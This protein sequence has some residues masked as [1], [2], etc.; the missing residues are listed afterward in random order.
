MLPGHQYTLTG[1]SNTL[2]PVTG[3][4]LVTPTIME[5]AIDAVLGVGAVSVFSVNVGATVT[6]VV[7][8]YNSVNGQPVA[9]PIDYTGQLQGITFDASQGITVVDNGCAPGA[10]CPLG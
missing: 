5:A 6:T 3:G 1:P 7:L 9:I 8:V 10:N 2:A 4:Q